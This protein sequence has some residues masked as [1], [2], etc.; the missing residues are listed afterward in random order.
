[1]ATVT[2]LHDILEFT[3]PS[4]SPEPTCELSESFSSTSLDSGSESGAEV[5]PCLP[6]R[7]K[8]VVWM[9][10]AGGSLTR[11]RLF[12][13]TD[14]TW[15]CSPK[16]FSQLFRSLNNT[17]APAAPA[18]TTMA[19]LSRLPGSMDE[20]IGHLGNHGVQLEAGFTQGCT[21]YATVRA[22]QLD[23]HQRVFVRW[24][25]DG[26]ATQHDTNLS[27]A[28]ASCDARTAIFLGALEASSAVDFAVCLVAGDREYWDNNSGS[29]YQLRPVPR[30]PV[31]ARAH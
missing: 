8:S 14:E 21:F 10:V 28:P 6:R 23:P 13:K 24:T 31:A 7:K 25:A 4:S 16:P 27:V 2:N 29:N 26:W 5:S 9:D 20:V 30:S 22:L 15:R 18:P 11:E 3:S 17:A 19:L 12:R 1:M